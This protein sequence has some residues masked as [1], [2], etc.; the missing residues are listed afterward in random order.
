MVAG[1]ARR[2]P[3]H[4]WLRVGAKHEVPRRARLSGQYGDVSV[5][6]MPEDVAGLSELTLAILDIATRV[7]DADAA[8]APDR[9]GRRARCRGGISRFPRVGRCSHPAGP[10]KEQAGR[11]SSLS[12]P[13][14]VSSIPPNH[15]ALGVARVFNCRRVSSAVSSSVSF[16]RVSTCSCAAF[17]HSSSEP[18]RRNELL[19]ALARTLIPS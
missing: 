12:F 8:V 2:E 3:A 17:R 9:G 13:A 6:V 4:Q 14:P 10:A 11:S 1:S 16:L 18:R 5:W 15:A 7:D 19:P